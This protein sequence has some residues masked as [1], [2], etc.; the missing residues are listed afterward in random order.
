[1]GR[2]AHVSWDRRKSRRNIH[3]GKVSVFFRGASWHIY[4]RENGK[5]RRIRIGPDRKEAENRAAEVNA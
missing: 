1:M 4:Y 5:A 3:V 2:S